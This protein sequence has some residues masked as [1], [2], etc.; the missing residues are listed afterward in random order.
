MKKGGSRLDVVCIGSAVRD[1]FVFSQSI[2]IIKNKAFASGYAE[3]LELGSK[4]QVEELHETS[5]G[6]AT[7]SAAT[8]AGL[9]FRTQVFTE[10][11]EDDAG[12]M[13][14]ADYKRRGILDSAHITKGS[15]TATSIILSQAGSDRAILTYRG[16]SHELSLSNYPLLT[17]KPRWF[18]VTSL[19][20][21]I[22]GYRSIL[23]RAEA[24]GAR[25]AWNPG[26]A[27]LALGLKKLKPFLE[28]TH[29]L[30]LNREEAMELA[31]TKE[32]DINAL[33]AA[34][35]GIAEYTVIT[36]GQNGAWMCTND[37]AWHAECKRIDIVST[38]GAG[39]AFG[40][41]LVS[42]FMQFG[43]PE[44]ALQLAMENSQAVIQHIGATT[45]ILRNMPSAKVLSQVRVRSW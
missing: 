19:H 2:A 25:V 17:V 34:L 21:N 44:Q 29:V 8:F 15:K 31:G 11:G 35:C 20:G 9:G 33:L 42:G 13:I 37:A 27:E 1:V 41:G 18:Y 36:D 32:H 16:T 45:G 40:S 30:L 39:D 6:G 3:C 38:T 10:L 28:R 12:K 43:N 26:S 5:G 7:N 14:R 4:H 23:D 22:A 24:C